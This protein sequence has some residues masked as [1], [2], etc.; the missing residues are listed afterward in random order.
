MDTI[1]HEFGP[2]LRDVEAGACIAPAS[3]PR[4]PQEMGTAGEAALC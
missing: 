2:M 1:H 4:V 3:A